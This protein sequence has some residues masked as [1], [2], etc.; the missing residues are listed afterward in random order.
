MRILVMFHGPFLDPRHT[1]CFSRLRCCRMTVAASGAEPILLDAGFAPACLRRTGSRNGKSSATGCF[2]C[3]SS[4]QKP[5]FWTNADRK[6]DYDLVGSFG[7][8]DYCLA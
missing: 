1:S 3:G 6:V 7:K 4:A 5:D 8:V 2:K